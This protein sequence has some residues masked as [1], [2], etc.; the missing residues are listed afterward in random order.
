MPIITDLIALG[1]SKNI[2]YSNITEVLNCEL[3]RYSG[4]YIRYQVKQ[5]TICEK[6]KKLDENGKRTI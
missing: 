3:D 2:Y 1:Y 6:V 5:G 4:E